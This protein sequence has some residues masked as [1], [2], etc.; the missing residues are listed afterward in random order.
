MLSAIFLYGSRARGDAGLDADTDILGVS[1]EDSFRK[2]SLN[3]VN[4]HCYPQEYL[5]CRSQEGD[6]FLLHLATE[7][8]ALYDPNDVLSKIRRKFV[9]KVDYVA[10]MDE[11]LGVFNWLKG[12]ID[13]GQQI[14]ARST[15]AFFWAVRTLLIA[16]SAEMRMPAFSS[17]KLG[18]ISCVD[19]VEEL[20]NQKRAVQVG[21]RELGLLLKVIEE[22]A[23]Y[24]TANGRSLDF[25]AKRTGPAVLGLVGKYL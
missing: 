4:I 5:I 21:K 11:A 15:R 8:V 25:G 13:A 3:N 7:A 2:I 19:G 22:S 17:A 9:Y 18:E 14:G 16:R 6:L 12:R 24:Q 20:L 23:Q 1:M 10:E